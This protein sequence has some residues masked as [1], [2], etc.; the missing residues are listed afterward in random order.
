MYIMNHS[1]YVKEYIGEIE[2]LCAIS[3]KSISGI[4][5]TNYDCFLESV[6][7]NYS[8]YIGQEE[9]V[10]SAIQGIAEIYNL[11]FIKVIPLSHTLYEFR[12]VLKLKLL[13]GTC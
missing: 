10:F 4:I 7:D 12:S 9:L 11:Q 3:K 2:K 6:T 13:G 1:E 5:T 8:Y